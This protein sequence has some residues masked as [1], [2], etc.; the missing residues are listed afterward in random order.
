ML[1]FRHRQSSVEGKT[2]QELLDEYDGVQNDKRNQSISVD[3]V[4]G[5]TV[6]TTETKPSYPRDVVTGRP[7]VD[8]GGSCLRCTEKG[9]RCTL[10]FVGVEGVG[11]CAAC[12]RSKA[13]RCIRQRAPEKRI[14]F[15]G[16]P[17]KNPNY[18]CVGEPFGCWDEMEEAL[19]E[20]FQGAPA[21]ARG[22]YLPSGGEKNMA[23]PPYNG[24]DRPID[25]RAENWK[26][27]DWK[28]V[29]PIAINRSYHPRP[30]NLKEKKRAPEPAPDTPSSVSSSDPSSASGST[31]SESQDSESDDEPVVSEEIL[32]HMVHFRKYQRRRI[33][34]QEYQRDLKETF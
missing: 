29:L 16:A 4:D 12:K 27:M 2:I 32:E 26:S 1:S 19:K 24:S 23:L 25:E 6:E 31:T 8:D 15:M 5:V 10:N 14:F 7:L 13:P 34:L 20:H 11:Q 33:H 30:I 3:E 9:L 22:M 28:R 21:Y 17:W 18:F